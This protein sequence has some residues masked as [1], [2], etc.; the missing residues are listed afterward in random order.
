M[1]RVGLAVAKN[2]SPEAVAYV[3]E[4]FGHKLHAQNVAMAEAMIQLARKKD[5]PHDALERLLERLKEAR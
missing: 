4:H 2:R 3:E 1:L 5:T